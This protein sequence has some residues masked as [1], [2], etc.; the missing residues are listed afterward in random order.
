MQT[1]R[2]RF[3]SVILGKKPVWLGFSGLTR[4]FPG[5]A[6]FFP[7]WLGFFLVFFDL[8][9]V[10]FGSVQFQAYKTEIEPNRLVFFKILISLIGFFSRFGFFGY[11]FFD[12]IGFLIFLLTS[13][14]NG[15]KHNTY[16]VTSI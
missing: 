16:L 5:L 10:R 11:F 9:L 15:T 13:T 7:V 8:G 3:C 12:L 14:V 6:W 1:D 2:F 4:F